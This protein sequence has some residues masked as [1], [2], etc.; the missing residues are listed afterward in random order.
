MKKLRKTNL[1]FHFIEL[2]KRKKAKGFPE[3][4]LF[5]VHHIHPKHDGGDPNGEVIKC[6]IPDHARAHYIRYKVYG[7]IYDLIAYYGLVHKTDQ[8]EKLIR[9]KI[10]SINRERQ[11]NMFNPEWQKEMASIWKCVHCAPPKVPRH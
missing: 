8:K 4:T 10:V 3:G 5:H 11:N 7:Q 2:L 1:Y 9:E 6:T